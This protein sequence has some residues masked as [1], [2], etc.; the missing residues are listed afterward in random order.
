MSYRRKDYKEIVEDIIEQIVHAVVK[1]RH[2]YSSQ[3]TR[4]AL[5]YEPVREIAKVEGLL[6][7]A[8]HVF[9]GDR[10]Y[11]LEDGALEWLAGG[12]RPDEGSAFFVSYTFGERGP[13]RMITDV[14]PGSVARTLV[15]S[16][17]REMDRLYAQMDQVYKSGFLDTA[18]GSALDNVVSI[19]GIER[20][21]AQPASG[22]VV[23]GRA[24]EPSEI[25]V[26]PEIILFDGRPRYDLKVAPVKAIDEVVGTARGEKH[27]FEAGLDFALVGNSLE[28]LPGGRR[29]DAGT[30]FTVKYR[31]YQ[32]VTIPSGTV[33]TTFS[34]EASRVKAFMTVS[35]GVL[36]LTSEGKWEA[37]VPVNAIS[38]GKGGNVPP[39]SITVMPKPPPG[40]EYVINR[41]AIGGGAEAEGDEELRERARRALEKVGRATLASLESAIRGVEGVRSSFVEDMPD[42]VRGLVRVIVQGGDEA[43]IRRVIEETRAAGVKVEF[44]RPSVVYVDVSLVVVLEKGAI[45]GFV[46]RKAEEVIRSY[47]SSLEIGQDVLYKRIVG[48]V[49]NIDGVR[50]VSELKLTA[51]RREGEPQVSTGENLHLSAQEL[52]EPRAVTVIV[53]EVE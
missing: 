22:K 21:P 14:N 29:P 10:D 34:R 37:E 32:A 1:E 23:F 15:E 9:R 31:A 48:G 36:G 11:G 16:F 53:E 45:E 3:M 38:A 52:A 19:L 18:S 12:E 35:E 17:A 20:K 47:V 30:E 50:D 39:G 26:E 5:E 8:R 4:Y 49:M 40:V 51:F 7:G 24:T 28:W 27:S 41:G 43:E 2:E 25:P 13:A 44:L 42:G 46:R 6:N 33:V